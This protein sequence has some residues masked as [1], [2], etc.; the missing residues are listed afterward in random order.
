MN[1]NLKVLFYLKKNQTK[2]SGLSPVMGRITIGRTMAQF[3]AKIEADASKWNA[4]AGRMT[5]KSNHALDVNRKIDKI[6]LSINKHYKELLQNK[7]QVT[8]EEVKNAFQG[9]AS[10]QETLL[11]IFADHNEN[12]C[13][14]IG[15]DR[16]ETTYKKYCNAYRHLSEFLQK[17]YHVQDM[18]FKQLNFAFIEAFDFYLRIEHKMKP[19]T[20][21]RNIVPLRKIV[22]IAV[23]KGYISA[24]PFAQY[25]PVRGK[26]VHRSLTG[27]E[28]KAI[29][30]TDFHTYFRNL[31]RDMFIF[32]AFTGMAYADIKKL[33]IKELVTTDDG[34]LWIVSARK[35]T[36]T[37]SRIRLLDVA[38]R[39]IKKYEKDRT[40]DNVF[41]MPGYTTVDI[42]LKRIAQ[43][44]GIENNISF[45]MGRHSFASQVCLSQGVP[46][47]TV[48]RMLGH[49]D[50]HTTQIYATVSTEKINSDM[51][52][53]SQRIA[54][55]F[56]LTKQPAETAINQ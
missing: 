37:V 43:I 15:I 5:G 24:D 4:K 2:V 16:E 36:G 55:K 52:K 11:K 39:I 26:S 23:N 48:S 53:L 35:K 47:E 22:R 21:L 17:K 9:I 18:S 10:V 32:S 49:R 7:G 33:T 31:S 14:R 30:S 34:N 13:K 38:V 40:N 44:C 45:H 46:I 3:S 54:G 25:K 56:S 12:Y 51:E 27:E 29:M 8:A 28:L 50:I 6:N 19:N 42:N 20:V 1:E 41:P